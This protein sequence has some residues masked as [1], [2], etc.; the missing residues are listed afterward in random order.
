MP[1]RKKTWKGSKESRSVDLCTFFGEY[2]TPFFFYHQFQEQGIERTTF[3]GAMHV[4][5]CS[6]ACKSFRSYS[7]QINYVYDEGQLRIADFKLSLRVLEGSRVFKA[8]VVMLEQF[9]IHRLL[10]YLKKP[11]VKA[12][13]LEGMER[14]SDLCEQMCALLPTKIVHLRSL[15]KNAERDPLAVDPLA[16]Q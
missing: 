12:H 13:G 5:M 6:A 15:E 4:A 3:C 16:V 14:E 2:L 1:G 8:R 10:E 7:K 9:P 11:P